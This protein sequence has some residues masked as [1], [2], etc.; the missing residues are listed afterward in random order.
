MTT[1]Y[2][3]CIDDWYNPF[4][5]VRGDVCIVVRKVG[6]TYTFNRS[7]SGFTIFSSEHFK[8]ISCPCKIKNCIMH[9]ASS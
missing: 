1:K 3:E 4:G 5:I 8:P 6:T 7:Y 9:R 2:V